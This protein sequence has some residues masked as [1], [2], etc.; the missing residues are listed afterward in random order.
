MP[1]WSCSAACHNDSAGVA[2]T[3]AAMERARARWN[4]REH[5]RTGRQCAIEK[6]CGGQGARRQAPYATAIDKREIYASVSW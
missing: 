6:W 3:L 2:N 4:E 5:W 1:I